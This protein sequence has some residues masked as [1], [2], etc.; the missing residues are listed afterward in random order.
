MRRRAIKTWSAVGL[1]QI[2]LDKI[3]TMMRCGVS[4]MHLFPSVVLEFGME[5]PGKPIHNRHALV[6]TPSCCV[7]GG[8]SGIGEFEVVESGEKKGMALIS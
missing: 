4:V 5:F 1:F 6:R 8:G 7:R 3:A 2:Y